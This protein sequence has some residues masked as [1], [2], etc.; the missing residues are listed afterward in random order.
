MAK[1][2]LINMRPDSKG[3]SYDR[4]AASQIFGFVRDAIIS[5]E[6]LPGQMISETALAQQFGVSR[7]PVREAL[8]QLS[9]IG[10][11]EVL[12]QRGTYVTKFSMEKIL[13]AR[14]I[15]EALEVA[16]V[17]QLAANANESIREE[18]VEACEKIIV[19]QKT[20]AA[21]D[22]ALAFQNLDDQFHQTLASFTQYPRAATLIE[23]EKAHMDRVR[24]LSLHVSGQYKR[25]L[26]QHA[27]ITKAIKAGSAEKSAAAM[28]VHLKD[29]YNILE[30]IPQE[31]PEYFI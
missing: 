22:D 12:P 4:P 29:V 20:A 14:F 1:Q 6:L 8:I 30:V 3:L 28:S 7:T 11:V 2:P 10:F 26:S 25:V 24:N 21:D 13:E 31:H 9:N 17:T 5:M 15:R 19:D 27:A 16:V 23:A 18:A